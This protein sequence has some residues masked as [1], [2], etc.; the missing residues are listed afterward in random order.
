MKIKIF[1]ITLLMLGF[2]SAGNV[3]AEPLPDLIGKTC[4]SPD[5]P[6]RVELYGQPELISYHETADGVVWMGY[7]PKGDFTMTLNTETNVITNIE[8]GGNQQHQLQQRYK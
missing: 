4:D 2:V 8:R 6:E 7:Y 1:I 3:F 5:V